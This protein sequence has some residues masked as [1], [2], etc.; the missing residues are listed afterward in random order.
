[1]KYLFVMLFALVLEQCT[2]T[3]NKKGDMLGNDV[4]LFEQTPVWEVAKAI[5]KEDTVKIKHLLAGKPSSVLN[6]QEKYYGQS[7]LNWAVYT[8]H[9][10]SVKALVELGANPNLKGNDSTS[11]FIQSASKFETSDYLKLL[12]QYGGDVN[13]VANIDAPQ[14]LRTPLMAAAFK[15]LENVKILVKA[16]ADVNYIH[17]SH[18][19]QSAL[20]YA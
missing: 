11:A 1:M 15:S 5:E 14:H 9:Y 16:G 3:P 8:N 18:G 6:Y 19:I 10:P 7:L 4:R 13:T 17:K 2:S 20:L 12:L